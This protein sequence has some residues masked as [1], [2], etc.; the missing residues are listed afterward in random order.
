MFRLI[1]PNFR[2]LD[3]IISLHMSANPAAEWCEPAQVME[4]V[5]L[6]LTRENS[7]AVAA[8]ADY[9]A[10]T[11]AAGNRIAFQE[12]VNEPLSSILLLE[13]YEY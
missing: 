8:M 5:R 3:Y 7:L 12:T 13:I 1:K 2:S 9:Y 10:E 6:P 4:F 11:G